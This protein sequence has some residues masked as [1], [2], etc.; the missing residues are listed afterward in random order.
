MN[1]G[2]QP[3]RF[4]VGEGYAVYRGP[5]AGGAF[6]RHAAFQIAVAAEGE[7]TVVDERETRHRGVALVVP[8]MARHRML[9][10]ADLLI[11]YIEPH[12][13]FADRLRERCGDGITAVPE[14]RDLREEDIGRAGVRPSAELDPRLV[15]ALNTL[16]ER[17][18]PMPSLAAAVGL[19]P[20]RLRALAR[21]QVGMPLA[22]WRVWARLRLAAE[23]MRAGRS[24]ADAAI[25]AGFTDQAHL[26]RQMREMMGLT[27]AAVLQHLRGQSRRA[28]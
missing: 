27:P 18:V 23:A 22:R 10:A 3:P 28:T 7:V 20:Q 25:E 11:F 14:L 5:A 2:T 17:S 19:S 6:H 26:T 16:K 15:A 12:C 1:A 4:A 24:P 9:T 21:H 8:P 13:V